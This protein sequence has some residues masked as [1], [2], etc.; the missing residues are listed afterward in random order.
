MCNQSKTMKRIIYFARKCIRKKP[1]R[2]S[3]VCAERL[4]Y[5]VTFRHIGRTSAI[6]H[7]KTAC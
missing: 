1:D 7:I 5:A 3:N 2:I 4:C 6:F